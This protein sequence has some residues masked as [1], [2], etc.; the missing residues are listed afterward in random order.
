MKRFNDLIMLDDRIGQTVHRGVKR[1][2]ASTALDVQVDAA[3]I[4]GYFAHGKEAKV[5]RQRSDAH[6]GQ[7]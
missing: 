2:A 6:S 5:R 7:G 1:E 3:Y 4:E